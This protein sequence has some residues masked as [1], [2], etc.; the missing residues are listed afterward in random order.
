MRLK[1]RTALVTGAGGP[2]GRAIATRFAA[3]GASLLLTDIS[4]NRLG[5]ARD[6]AVAAGGTVVAHRAD[7]TSEHEV[8]GLLAEGRGT[9]PPVDILINV[10]GGIRDREMYR[11]ILEMDESR[12]H[13]TFRL[14]LVG[15]FHLV[16]RLAPGMVERGWGRIVNFSS[17][18]Y[19]GAW[20]HTDYGAAKAAVSSLTRTLA[21]ELSPHV[22]VNAVAPGLIQT[23]VTERLSPEEQ[24]RQSEM[25]VLKRMGK[26]EEVAAVVLFLA[27][28]DAS[29]LTGL[30]VPVTGGIWPSL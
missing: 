2:M 28:D 22:L 30:T 16:K 26:P 17:V 4:A 14:N 27:S 12:W 23:S 7:V 11:P 13:D 24:R 9:L 3:E 25:A 5:Q 20:G 15:T 1:G 19:A 8:D 29:Y 21:I 18:N 6:A 10:V